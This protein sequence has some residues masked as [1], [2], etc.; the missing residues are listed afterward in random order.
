MRHVI[1]AVAILMLAGCGRDS[2]IDPITPATNS[3]AVSGYV[4]DTAGRSIDQ[5]RIEVVDGPQAGAV[6]LSD[7]RG[8]FSFGQRFTE[9]NR[10]RASKDG[11][12]TTD[13]SVIRFVGTN[14]SYPTV[15]SFQL[16]SLTPSIDLTGGYLVTI[17]ADAACTGLPANATSRTYVATVTRRSVDWAYIGQLSGAIFAPA[18]I[19]S[20][21]YDRFLANVFGTVVRFGFSNPDDYGIVEQLGPDS[22]VDISGT[23]DATV[24]ARTS[25]VEAPFSGYFS[26]CAAPKPTFFDCTIPRID[27]TSTNHRLTLTRISSPWDY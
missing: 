8:Q 21:H 22:F 16:A 7:A 9:G 19:A 2:D 12:R 18:P 23:A 6:T 1:T 4:T 10:I 24:E 17:T 5:A 15:V 20:L 14:P 27:C 3:F 25:S 11:Y 13:E 26:Y